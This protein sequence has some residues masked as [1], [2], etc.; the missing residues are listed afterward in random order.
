LQAV[1]LP[2]AIDLINGIKKVNGKWGIV[3]SGTFGLATQWLKVL[4]HPYNYL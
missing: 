1:A 3:T 2:G 4:S